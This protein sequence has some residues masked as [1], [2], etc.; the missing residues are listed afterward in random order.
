MAIQL[1]TLSE[2][3]R[4]AAIRVA[5]STITEARVAGRKT[6]FL[7]H[8]HKD[9][10]YVRGLV[11]LLQ[12]AG[13]TAYVDWMDE[14]MPP[15]PNR[16]TAEKIKTRIKQVDYFMFLATPNS[17]VS[18]WCPW[19]IGYADGVKPID[20]ILLVQ[21]RDAQGNNYGSEYLNL[22]RHVD[23]SKQGNLAAWRPGEEAGTWVRA[24]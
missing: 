17:M 8:S 21:T 20:T 24:L 4:R 7:C 16:T 11:Q 15:R 1:A 2:A 3:S 23:I 12:E 22:Y 14:T 5:K 9:E 6:V 13:W 19:E 10:Q 18:R